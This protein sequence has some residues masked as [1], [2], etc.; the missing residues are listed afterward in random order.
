MPFL[1]SIFIYFDKYSALF[2]SALAAKILGFITFFLLTFIPYPYLRMN[3]ASLNKKYLGSC[4]P[5]LAFSLGIEVL[6]RVEVFF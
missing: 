2:K 5:Q 1:S 3:E 4:V 6:E